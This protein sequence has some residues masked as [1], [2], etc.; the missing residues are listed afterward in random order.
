MMVVAPFKVN[1]PGVKIGLFVPTT[2]NCSV[3]PL[4][5]PTV[6]VVGDRYVA[7][8]EGITLNVAPSRTVMFVPRDCALVTTKVPLLNVS[9][10][11][12]LFAPES[13]NWLAALLT[14]VPLPVITPEK[15]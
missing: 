6:N 1:V 8:A 3:A 10:P 13:V 5:L 14:K 2:P 12:K 4:L 15:V 7:F 11:V 9:E